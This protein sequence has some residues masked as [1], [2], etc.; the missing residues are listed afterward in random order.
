VE[1]FEDGLARGQDEAA[2]EGQQDHGEDGVGSQPLGDVLCICGV[3]E[4][5]D[6]VEDGGQ[7]G[8]GAHGSSGEAIG[9]E[10][11]GALA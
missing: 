3:C 1:V 9:D 7:Q 6:L 4:I 11:G 5:G 8:R 2:G 10:L